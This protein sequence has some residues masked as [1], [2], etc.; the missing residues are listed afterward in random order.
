MLLLKQFYAIIYFW[1]KGWVI[2]LFVGI[3]S[4]IFLPWYVTYCIAGLL[5]YTILLDLN[6]LSET[7]FS[8][9][10]FKQKTIFFMNLKENYADSHFHFTKANQILKKFKVDKN[11]EIGLFGMYFDNASH[12]G[13]DKT[14]Y[15]V[16]I[17]FKEGIIPSPE[18]EEHFILQGW[19]KG[20]TSLCSAIVSRVRVVH[21]L[22]S[23]IA[24]KR[25]YKDLQR[26]L[27]DTKFLKKFKIENASS[28]PCV[29]EI[30]KQNIVE[31]Y[32]P[33]SHQSSFGFYDATKIQ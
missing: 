14:R 8:F 33:I 32:L 5:I 3:L 13:T 17:Y 19:S 7:K 24:I 25:Y 31:M 2:L 4:S 12:V 18:L 15:I 27:C 21:H 23:F 22:V 30:Y 6:I 29:I 20:V 11:P 1:M 26:N 16:G 10:T 9:G 28:I